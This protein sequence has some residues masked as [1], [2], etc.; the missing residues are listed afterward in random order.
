[1]KIIIKDSKM[2]LKVKTEDLALAQVIIGFI[3]NKISS[4][5]V[6]NIFRVG[7]TV[8]DLMSDLKS[9]A[10][11]QADS[12]KPTEEK[13]D[14]DSVPQLKGRKPGR[15]LGA[16]NKHRKF[17][18]VDW[19]DEEI[20]FLSDTRNM[21]AVY[22]L[23]APELKRHTKAAILSKRHAIRHKLTNNLSKH[24]LAIIK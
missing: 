8:G 21:K 20:I 9:Q 2:N 16:K 24:Q 11:S 5:A 13:K 23:A 4:T 22:V 15:P 1:M 12:K 3:R 10:N 19:T 6:K 17:A 7:Y 18:R 14:E